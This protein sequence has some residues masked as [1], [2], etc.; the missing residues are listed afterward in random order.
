M[1]QWSFHAETD[2]MHLEKPLSTL[3]WSS[4]N[5]TDKKAAAKY[6]KFSVCQMRAPETGSPSLPRSAYKNYMCLFPVY[7]FLLPLSY[8]ARSHG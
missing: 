5:K 4:P 3:M 6:W 8:P 2:L 7:L 1:K